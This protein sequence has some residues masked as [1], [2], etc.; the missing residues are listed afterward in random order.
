MH[1][2]KKGMLDGRGA[3]QAPYLTFICWQRKI[4]RRRGPGSDDISI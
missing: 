1:C 4:S 2:T 3:F